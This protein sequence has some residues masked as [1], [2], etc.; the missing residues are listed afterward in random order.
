MIG[1]QSPFRCLAVLLAL[2]AA[3][4]T[5]PA[6]GQFVPGHVFVSDPA[7]DLC[8]HTDDWGIPFSVERIL[9]IDPYQQVSRIFATIPREWCGF[10]TGMAFST[11][12]SS[13]SPFRT[14]CSTT[15][16]VASGAVTTR[17]SAPD[18]YRRLIKPGRI[19]ASCRL[20]VFILNNPCGYFCKS[21]SGAPMHS[22]FPS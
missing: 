17:S 18:G 21:S 1:E 8:T 14:H 15:S 3:A 22:N 12:P 6:A 2:W 7:S 19:P 9:E 5:Q 4:S 10:I 16:T 11:A 20:P 13:R